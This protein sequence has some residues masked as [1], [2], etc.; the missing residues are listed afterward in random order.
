MK[1]PVKVTFEDIA[2]NVCIPCTE[3]EI[4]EKGEKTKDFQVLKG[5]SGGALPG[6]TTVIIG[7]SG[8]GKTS[9]LNILSQ[10][11][12]LRDG[13]T[14]TGSVKFNDKEVDQATFAKYAAYVMQDDILFEHFT[15]KESITFGARL[16]L[17][18]LTKEKQDEKV[19]EMIENLGLGNCQNTKVGS[20]E[21]RGLSG[22][23][24]KRL[25]IGYELITDPSLILLDEP[26]SGLDSFKATNLSKFLSKLS[27]Q[28]KTIVA[29]IH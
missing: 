22:G 6:Q 8:A 1:N 4:K 10:R 18:H 3:D 2:Y 25:A 17:A 7:A 12:T 9:L 27:R 14:L 15:V 26:T 5:V 20:V 16:R 11:V 19:K 13:A 21:V 29:T 28:G 23:E 24:R